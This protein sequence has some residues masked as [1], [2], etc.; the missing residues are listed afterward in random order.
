M[1]LSE[2]YAHKA[3]VG[4]QEWCVAT[5]RADLPALKYLFGVLTVPLFKRK[6]GPPQCRV[7]TLGSQASS[8][9]ENLHYREKDCAGL[10]ATHFE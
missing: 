9:I 10:R 4:L 6:K 3:V 5:K 8:E 7:V 1:T 2:L